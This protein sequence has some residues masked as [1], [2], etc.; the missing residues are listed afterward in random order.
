ME[1]GPEFSRPVPLD[2]IAE[3]ER[4]LEIAA[5]EGERAALARRF[6]LVRLDRLEATVRLSRSGVFY[7]LEADWRADVVQTCVVTLDPLASRLAERLVERYG[8]TDRDEIDLDLDPEA[9][10][11]EAI[12]GGAIDVGEAV[13]QALSLALDPYPRKPGAEIEIPAGKSGEQGPF[14]ALSRLRREP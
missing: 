3:R 4:V 9:D 14:A 5:T 12:E 11:P 13:A 1:P 7:R 10:A 6:D 8:P 2:Q